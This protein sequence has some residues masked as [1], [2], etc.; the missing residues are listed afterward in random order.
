MM[1]FRYRQSPNLLELI[2]AASIGG[3][4]I[5]PPGDRPGMIQLDRIRKVA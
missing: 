3:W 5:D 1:R 4:M 2:S